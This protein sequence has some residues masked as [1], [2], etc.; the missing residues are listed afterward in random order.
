VYLTLWQRVEMAT[1][2]TKWNSTELESYLIEITSK[3][4]NRTDDL[5]ADGSYVVDKILDKTGSKGM[6]RWTVQE[7]AEQS[8][9]A[10]V[11]AAALDGR[12]ISSRKEERIVASE[13]LHCPTSDMPS[14]GKEQL[15]ADLQAALY[16]AKLA[17]GAQG[18][19]IIEAA[20]IK[21]RWNADVSLCAMVWRAGCIIRA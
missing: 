21:H 2:F 11:I 4:L 17:S 1:L 8:I 3:I 5:V 18:M 12:Y 10:P 16:C 13:I 14:I 7:A 19:G 20:S 6:G 9:A 15:L